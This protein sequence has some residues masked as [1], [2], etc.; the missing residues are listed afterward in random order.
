MFSIESH[1]HILIESF[2]DRQ[3]TLKVHKFFPTSVLA[4]VFK[5]NIEKSPQGRA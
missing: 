2:R 3:T 1:P 4:R 5:L